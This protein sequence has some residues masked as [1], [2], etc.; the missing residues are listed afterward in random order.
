MTDLQI[1]E[2]KGQDIFLITPIIAKIGIQEPLKAVVDSLREENREVFDNEDMTEEE[3]ERE[4][5]LIGIDALGP[6][7]D[8]VISR[9]HEVQDEMNR[10]LASVCEVSVDEIKEVSFTDYIGLVTKLFKQE[11]FQGFFKQL[12]SST[13]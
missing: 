5:V 13:K 4:L 6:A 1:R 2:L 9:I 7:L 3:K 10:L 8:M 12:Y 11:Q